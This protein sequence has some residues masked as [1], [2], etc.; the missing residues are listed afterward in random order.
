MMYLWFAEHLLCSRHYA[1]HFYLNELFQLSL[2]YKIDSYFLNFI[3]KETEAQRDEVTSLR[4]QSQQGSD[5]G[6]I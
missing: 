2:P 3:N 4:S 6:Q 5:I 1:K